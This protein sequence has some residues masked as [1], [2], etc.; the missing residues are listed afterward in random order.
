[1]IYSM[2]QWPLSTFA[3][4]SGCINL[5]VHPPDATYFGLDVV[6]YS[7]VQRWKEKWYHLWGQRITTKNHRGPLP[8]SLRGLGPGAQEC[9]LVMHDE[10]DVARIIV[11]ARM[12][13]TAVRRANTLGLVAIP[14]PF[15][16]RTIRLD[17]ERTY[18]D[19][20]E[21]VPEGLWDAKAEAFVYLAKKADFALKAWVSDLLQDETEMGRLFGYPQCCIAAYKQHNDIQ[22]ISIDNI[23]GC[24]PKLTNQYSRLFGFELISHKPCSPDCS[25]TLLLA[26]RYLQILKSISPRTSM[27]LMGFLSAP[28]VVIDPANFIMPINS[29]LVD[30]HTLKGFTSRLL[31]F[32]GIANALRQKLVA[33]GT[34]VSFQATNE[35]ILLQAVFFSILLPDAYL[36][37]HNKEK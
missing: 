36:I 16:F 37:F 32:G 11:P 33:N 22:P 18:S 13:P 28:V 12:V 8:E 35:G 4:N 10:R 23:V 26:R 9:L 19:S 34:M 15:L 17:P 2:P 27:Y 29:T 14:S 1:M 21:L 6:A 31:S 25:E 7:L 3:T 5:A 24:A 20:V 30:K